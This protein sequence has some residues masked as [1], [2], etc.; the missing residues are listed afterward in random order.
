MSAHIPSSAPTPRSRRHADDAPRPHRADRDGWR[1]GVRLEIDAGGTIAS[2]ETGV[3]ARAF[4]ADVLL[5]APT[6]VHSHAFQRAMAGRAERRGPDGRD[7]FWSWR[8]LMYRFLERLGPDDIE[9][10]AAFVQLEMLEA[11]FA[12]VAEFHYLHHAPDGAEY[13]DL[14]ELSARIAA[15][16]E[17][18][19][20]GL[21]LLPTLYAV[22]G[23][24]GR[25]LEGGQ[26][27]FGND[28]TR[29]AALHE[30]A[31]NALRSL[32]GDARLGVA[33]HSLR[34]VSPAQLR[35]AATLAPDAPFHLHVAEQ[36]AEIDEVRRALGA[37]PVEWLLANHDVGARW[38][39]IHATHVDDAELAGLASSGAVAGLCPITEANLGDG[40]FEAER[41][42]DAGGALGLGT[43]SNLRVSLA[44]ELRTLEH[45]QRLRDGARA[46]LADAARSTGRRLLEE[47]CAGGARA[48]GRASG[49]IEAGR[50]ADLVA[51]DAS[52]TSL[53]GTDGDTTID[54][55]VF[56]GGDD[57]VT[58][59]W[60]AGRHVVRDG[61]H[62]RR[63]AIEARYR[64]TLLALSAHL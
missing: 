40:L 39:L 33:A 4:D 27:R 22:G 25:A 36:P 44:G 20:I 54:A 15:A 17:T 53:L 41:H 18:T 63:D 12:A 42:L 28:E 60:A 56:A 45:G 64:T 10:I 50:L 57:A 58:D 37:R 31:A 49:A 52:A 21:T 16:A 3:D 61:R 14:G 19:G 7:S 5:P 9:A 23:C 11:G 62:V 8:A 38:C 6:N 43:D 34:A 55:F 48:A 46:V 2:L 35:F 30:R 24:D 29:F 51:L 32:P 47:A 13:A 1:T 26:R 59:V